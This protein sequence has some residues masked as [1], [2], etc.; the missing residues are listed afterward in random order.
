[1]VTDFWTGVFER[2]SK[3]TADPGAVLQVLGYCVDLM[4]EDD[5]HA[6]EDVLVR[7]GTDTLSRG[8]IL[9][10]MVLAQGAIEQLVARG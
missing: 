7:D 2:L 5:E 3:D 4:T 9:E 1:M 8:E 6:L 10:A